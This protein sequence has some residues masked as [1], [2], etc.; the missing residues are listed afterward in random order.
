ML[1]EEIS[2]TENSVEEDS[3][4]EIGEKASEAQPIVSA[5]Q[6]A[7]A[8]NEKNSGT[9]YFKERRYEAAIVCYS[10]AI[11]KNPLVASYYSNRAVCYIRTEA[12]GAAIIDATKALEVDPTCEVLLLHAASILYSDLNIFFSHQGEV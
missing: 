1:I 9:V 8:E 10:S 5:E 3:E 12:Y 11:D 7:E 6:A 2:S 4:P